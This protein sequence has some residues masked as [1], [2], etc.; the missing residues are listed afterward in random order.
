MPQI[1]VRLVKE[2]SPDTTRIEDLYGA[3]ELLLNYTPLLD[4]VDTKCK[5]VFTESVDGSL[6]T[7]EATYFPRIEH[8][9]YENCTVQ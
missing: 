9:C 7:I 2:K 1:L 4:L 8:L 3:M 6:C 5:Y